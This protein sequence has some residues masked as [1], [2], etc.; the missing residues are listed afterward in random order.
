MQ[1][2]FRKPPKR[3]A[4]ALGSTFKAAGSVLGAL[5]LTVRPGSMKRPSVARIAVPAGVI[6]P[7]AATIAIARRR[8]ARAPL[9][10]WTSTSMTPTEPAPEAVTPPPPGPDAELTETAR[11][12]DQATAAGP[13]A[14]E[15]V[16]ETPRSAAG[17]T[18][19]AAEFSTGER[20]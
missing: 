1:L 6:V 9:E 5:P 4:K 7:A 19:A 17:E 10:T 13:R 11:R 14:A 2:T 3:R 20:S 8:R 18:P 15:S 16:V 12:K